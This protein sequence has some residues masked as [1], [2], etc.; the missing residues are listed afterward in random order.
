[1]LL[2][3]LD[4]DVGSG[5]G[6]GGPVLPR[7]QPLPDRGRGLVGVLGPRRGLH[8]RSVNPRSARRRSTPRSTPAGSWSTSEAR[9]DRSSVAAMS[10][11]TTTSH[12]GLLRRA[13]ALDAEHAAADRRADFEIPAGMVYLDGNS[14]GA[15]PR[16]VGPAMADAVSRQWGQ[17][18]I[19]S[20]NESDWWAA[21]TR[22]GDRIGTLVGAAPGQVVV[23]D[24]TSVN[25]YKALV[26]AARMRPGRTVAL[27]DPGS[28]PTDL[29]VMSAAARD[30]GLT[31]ELVPP[32][33]AQDAVRR[34]G[35]RLAVAA[36]SSVDYRTGELWDLP[37]ITR[38]AHE[39][40]ALACWDLCH[41]RRG[42]RCATRRRR[43]G[44]GGGLRL[45]VPQRWA[46]RP[47]VHL[48]AAR[49]PGVF[50]PPA[51]RVERPRDA[52]RD[53]WHLSAGRGNRRAR[54][55]TPPVLGVLA[56]EAALSVYDGL[57][58]SDV[59]ARSLS[60]TGFFVECLDALRDRP[61]GDDAARAG[62]ARV[63]GVAATPRGVRRRAGADGARPPVRDRRLPR[64]GRG[65]ARFRTALP[66]TRR[67]AGRGR[68]A[69]GSVAGQGV[70]SARAPG[71]R[72][73]DLTAAVPACA[74]L[75]SDRGLA[76]TAQAG[77]SY[78]E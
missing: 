46:R 19:R 12:A 26:A 52:V 48:C 36:Y 33:E 14:L 75:P 53:G 11:S 78:L 41:S 21:P 39:V 44:P 29:Y 34:L 63:A 43:R 69:R 37:A 38:A 49:A 20:W 25:L 51:D 18:L 2:G 72:Y 60:L 8:S 1:M 67:C 64:A 16:A 66:V 58:L 47:G 7:E 22:V 54:T 42:G 9:L 28:F 57:S 56:L 40:G 73:G 65:Q 13:E 3:C 23:G 24:S 59:R 5:L 17:R 4:R 68:A 71:P 10:A 31:V 30:A 70:R 6:A 35:G 50:R 74:V 15:L 61:A 77:E 76:N 32:R 62:S 55:G 45:Q 27:T